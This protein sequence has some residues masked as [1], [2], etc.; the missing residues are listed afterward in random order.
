MCFHTKY[1]P[2]P[3]LADLKPSPTPEVAAH[4]SSD[5][6]TLNYSLN[7]VGLHLAEARHSSAWATAERRLTMAAQ[8]GVFLPCLWPNTAAVLVGTTPSTYR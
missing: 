5:S 3:S 1:I 2:I 6:F 8:L 4:R 7:F